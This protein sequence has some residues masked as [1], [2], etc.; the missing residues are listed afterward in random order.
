MS[1]REL[2]PYASTQTLDLDSNVPDVHDGQ[3]GRQL[4]WRTILAVAIAGGVF[5][6]GALFLVAIGSILEALLTMDVVQMADIGK[7]LLG[8]FFFFF[9]GF[10]LAGLP[11]IVIVPLCYAVYRSRRDPTNPLSGKN[12]LLFGA[13]CG[14]LCGSVPMSVFSG[15]Q[16]EVIAFSLLPGVVG[17]GVTPLALIRYSRRVNQSNEDRQ[18]ALLAEKGDRVVSP[19]AVSDDLGVNAFRESSSNADS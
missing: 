7:V 11:A 2:N 9:I 8:F 3:L 1:T 4:I 12:V 17:C 14:F 19:F 10:A 15:L 16:P 6:A 18:N 5:G 13:I